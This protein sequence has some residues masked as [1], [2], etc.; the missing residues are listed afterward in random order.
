MNLEKLRHYQHCVEHIRDWFEEYKPKWKLPLSLS[1]TLWIAR[2][3]LSL[4]TRKRVIETAG[5]IVR[6][7]P[8]AKEEEE[9]ALTFCKE[10]SDYA[11]AKVE[12]LRR[13]SLIVEGEEPAVAPP[14]PPEHKAAA[15][16]PGLPA[17]ISSTQYSSLVCRS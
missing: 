3:T 11:R 9:L 2:I 4:R 14:K 5:A 16:Q 10:Q 13:L 12:A 7:P 15:G 1:A 8:V 17:G 6:K